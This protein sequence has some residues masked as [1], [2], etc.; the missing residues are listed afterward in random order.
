[1]YGGVGFNIY[2]TDEEALSDSHLD[3][4]A[5][6]DVLDPIQDDEDPSIT[7]YILWGTGDANTTPARSCSWGT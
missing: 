5:T 7:Y 2:A 3:V 6:L 1:M 4:L